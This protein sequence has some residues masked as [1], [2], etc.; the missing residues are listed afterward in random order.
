MFCLLYSFLISDTLLMFGSTKRA[1]S[2]A[3]PFAFEEYKRRKIRE[4]I[5]QE[6]PSRIKVED[7]LPKVNRELASRL[8]NDDSRKKKNTANLLQDNRF[9]VSNIADREQLK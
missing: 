9:K 8:M 2:I 5:E 3:D 7:N 6:R 4:K 1:K